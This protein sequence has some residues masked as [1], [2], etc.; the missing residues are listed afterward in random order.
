LFGGASGG[1]EAGQARAYDEH[2]ARQI[3]HI[4]RTLGTGL[5]FIASPIGRGLREAAGED[6]AEST[7]ILTF[8]QRE[9]ERFL[10]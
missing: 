3:S 10:A 7:L 9:K 1:G 4:L 6:L 2:I 5:L 8:S